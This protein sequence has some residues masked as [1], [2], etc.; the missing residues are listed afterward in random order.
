VNSVYDT[1]RQE[2]AA[3]RTFAD[4]PRL[5]G[6]LRADLVDALAKA[7]AA[8]WRRDKGVAQR[9]NGVDLRDLAGA[10]LD[11]EAPGRTE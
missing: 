2:R 3:E 4:L 10:G 6:E 1:D 8:R 9:S 11:R 7:I 5:S